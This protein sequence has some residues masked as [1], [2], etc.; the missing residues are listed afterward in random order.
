[1]KT[2]IN[3]FLQSDFFIL[4]ISLF[5]GFLCHFFATTE[6]LVSDR[7]EKDIKSL[8]ISAI[9]FKSLKDIEDNKMT[10]EN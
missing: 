1:M 7:K 9:N 2:K 6:I 8:Y 10:S 4:S 3:N 5:L